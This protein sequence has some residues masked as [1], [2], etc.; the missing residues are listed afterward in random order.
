MQRSFYRIEAPHFVAAFESETRGDVERV[1]V[2]API[3]KWMIG[4][5]VGDVLGYC[6]RKGW[7]INP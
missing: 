1:V 4:K 2:A 6:I 7:R 3:I 5:A